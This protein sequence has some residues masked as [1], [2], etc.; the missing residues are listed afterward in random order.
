M[1]EEEGAGVERSEGGGRTEGR[2]E[3][4]LRWTGPTGTGWEARASCVRARMRSDALVPTTHP[5]TPSS[6]PCCPGDRPLP[7]SPLFLTYSHK[8]LYL[9][10]ALSLPQE[11]FVHSQVIL[12][13][14]P[15]TAFHTTPSLQYN[16]PWPVHTKKKR[17]LCPRRCLE[18]ATAKELR[19]LHSWP[20]RWVPVLFPPDK[21]GNRGSEK[22]SNWP[23]SQSE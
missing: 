13:H 19:C 2:G 20:L 4:R 6:E 18:P 8:S 3:R 21:L 1:G 14:S 23:E 17:L 15:Y 22:L 12:T 10:H 5:D 7:G 11:P 9:P 16:P